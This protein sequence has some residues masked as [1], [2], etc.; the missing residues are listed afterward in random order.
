MNIKLKKI[1]YINEDKEYNELNIFIKNEYINNIK[2][3][4]KRSIK[5]ENKKCKTD[6]ILA[7]EITHGI[8]KKS[9]K[10]LLYNVK[11]YSLIYNNMLEKC[12]DKF[13]ALEEASI[14]VMNEKNINNITKNKKEYYE[15]TIKRSCYLYDNYY[16]ILDKIYFKFSN[17]SA[18][19]EIDWENWLDYETAES[20]FD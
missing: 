11:Y 10:V 15:R 18:L 8:N 7:K 1:K 3:D 16:C 6:I 4:E 17:L 12:N 9:Y 20:D 5:F 14:C 2:N 19:N 13:S